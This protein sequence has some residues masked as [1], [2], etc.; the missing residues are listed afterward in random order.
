MNLTGV[1]YCVKSCQVSIKI[2]KM[3]EA[4]C[5]KI[6]VYVY[7][8]KTLT[9]DANITAEEICL[10]VA[11]HI[12]Y[13]DQTL[14]NRDFNLFQ[15]ATKDLK[16]WISPGK[17]MKESTD[18][19]FRLRF[20]L[21]RDRGCAPLGKAA[22][23]YYF[24]Q[25]QHDFKNCKWNT[26]KD[27]EILG[28]AVMD[29]ARASEEDNISLDKVLKNYSKFLPEDM[30]TRFAWWPH[31][32]STLKKRLKDGLRDCQ[33]RQWK[34]I[35]LK[36]KYIAQFQGKCEN[37]GK[38][39][40]TTADNLNIEV[41]GDDGITIRDRELSQNGDIARFD[42]CDI[43]DVIIEQVTESVQVQINRRKG[44]GLTLRMYDTDEAESL[45]SLLNGY[46][47]LLVD[48]YH[49][50]C[51][52]CA[53]PM[54]IKLGEA[55]CHGPITRQ[56]ADEK[57]RLEGINN[58]TYL[59][60]QNPDPAKLGGYCLMLCYDGKINNYPV[61]VSADNKI[62][63][64][65]ENKMSTLSEFIETYKTPNQ[66]LQVP[67]KVCV[68]PVPKEK[69]LLLKRAGNGPD[70]PRSPKPG[71]R[72]DNSES[73]VW[74]QEDALT[75]EE[76]LGGGKFTKVHKGK[77]FS[78]LPGEDPASS[79][80]TVVI[81][82]LANQECEKKFEKVFFQ[83][84]DK[85]LFL[86]NPHL[87]PIIGVRKFVLVMEYVQFG[88]LNK[89]LQMHGPD[90]K[91]ADLLKA[92]I[93]IAQALEYL[94][95]QSVVHGSICARNVLVASEPNQFHVKLADPLFGNIYYALKADHEARLN[96]VPW[97][98]PEHLVCRVRAN[99]DLDKFAYGV[100]CWEVFSLG[101]EPF[102]K[103]RHED[104]RKMYLEGKRPPL[105]GL[106]CS[107]TSII[108]QC[109]HQD[110]I[111]RPPFK[112]VLRDFRK[113]P[114]DTFESGR[115]PHEW[116]RSIS[117]IHMPETE[118][119]N[120]ANGG[121]SGVVDVPVN[122]SNSEDFTN[123]TSSSGIDQPQ[124]QPLQSRDILT[125][126]DLADILDPVHIEIDSLD[127]KEE[128]GHGHYGL[129]KKG[130]LKRYP[131][132][133]EK[134][135]EVAVKL[136]PKPLANNKSHTEEFMQEIRRTAE[137]DCERVV[138]VKGICQDK[139]LGLMMVMEYL[140]KGALNS[141]L[142][143]HKKLNIKILCTYSLQVAEGMKY[144]A[145]K[146]VVHRDL[147][148]RNIL[149]ATMDS[150]K[151]SDFGLARH[152][153]GGS[154][155]SLYYRQKSH[156]E[157]PILWHAPESISN[158]KYDSKG[159]VW[160]Y[161]VLLWEIFTYGERPRYINKGNEVKFERLL[162]DLYQGLRLSQPTHCEDNVYEIMKKCWNWEPKDR[163]DFSE[164]E[165]EFQSIISKIK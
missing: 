5:N 70:I 29:M 147:A 162:H 151:I 117:E 12:N 104:I 1:H 123:E 69:S 119:H 99:R 111:E 81:K 114:A 47:R 157:N 103:R 77:Y 53:S 110:P 93:Q 10:Q 30:P 41:S 78:N 25:C 155:S 85:I 64:P 125:E 14:S 108:N 126:D 109:W 11:R 35:E 152:M 156:Q 165:G 106:P 107:V 128:L 45:V 149:V 6:F 144:L 98:P 17:K 139:V 129:V 145:S 113:I 94:E 59:I 19:V 71:Y 116:S 2:K 82:S 153:K 48:Y 44:D 163:P 105:D 33:Q 137:L 49:Y 160:G 23:E 97:T 134:N 133:P 132:I 92:V 112:C 54:Q 61:D 76:E 3:A 118:M 36:I 7:T 58:G 39:V 86:E 75:F 31:I 79:H 34:P 140:P 20:V 102:Q 67:L 73:G 55:K 96:R 46:Y 136:L 42:F 43:T 40:Y 138:K 62:S 22:Q 63:F 142:N 60:R 24:R 90:M 101:H 21:H 146:Q 68:P 37:F 120:G 26:F 65:G 16:T 4:T 72:R 8:G 80:N 135:E 143:K 13:E 87:I 52:D 83:S 28:M 115:L 121:D 74:I 150:V 164:L 161:G 9:F 57:I 27:E 15:L 84:A 38:E 95:E 158:K 141:H 130:I 91:P 148:A 131:N 159:D 18:L 127:L 32:K 122:S 66:C 100:C 56:D 154:N 50:L 51:Y 124:P 89:Y 88:S